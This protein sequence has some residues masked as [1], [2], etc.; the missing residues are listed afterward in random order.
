MSSGDW[1]SCGWKATTA[2]AEQEMMGLACENCAEGEAH[3]WL[4]AELET[5]ET[6][7]VAATVLPA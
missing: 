6:T 7:A 2:N 4:E 1:G 5:P 3:Y